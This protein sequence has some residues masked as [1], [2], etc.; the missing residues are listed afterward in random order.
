MG[1]DE[2]NPGRRA[3]TEQWLDGLGV[4]WEYVPEVPLALIDQVASLGNQARL[5]PL[6]EEVVERY[7]DDMARGDDFPAVLLHRVGKR[8]VLA[9]GNHRIT[10][11][12]RNE[13]ATFP[14]Y[15]LIDVEPAVLTRIMYEDNRWHGLP[16]SETERLLQAAHLVLAGAYTRQEAAAITGAHLSKV[17]RAVETVR[18]DER[19]ATLNIPGWGKLAGSIRWRLG[20]L[21][22]DRVFTEAAELAVASNMSSD[23][24]YTLVQRLNAAPSEEAALKLLADERNRWAGATDPVGLRRRRA[25]SKVT[26]AAGRIAEVDAEDVVAACNTEADRR[27]LHDH[28]LAGQVTLSQII[29]RLGL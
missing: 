24:V 29:E 19:A 4:T 20:S 8:L 3:D 23:P 7:A 21:A 25:W 18:A 12:V 5:R 17:G 15:M 13:R 28:A 11:A 22:S 2:V 9:G 16:S 10:A 6:D 26:A 27:R 1:V 14:G